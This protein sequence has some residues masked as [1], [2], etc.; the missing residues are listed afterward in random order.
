M[1]GL[2]PCQFCGEENDIVIVSGDC[3]YTTRS[4]YLTKGLQYM[5]HVECHHCSAQG[6]LTAGEPSITEAESRA[7]E[8]WNDAY[9]PMTMVEKIERFFRQIKYDIDTFIEDWKN[10]DR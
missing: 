9:V 1:T 10:D 8:Y 2:N 4:T 6:S 5:A 7:I 3:T